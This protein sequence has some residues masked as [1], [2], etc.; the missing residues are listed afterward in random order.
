MQLLQCLDEIVLHA[1]HSLLH[2]CLE[3]NPDESVKCIINDM[4]QPRSVI[5]RGMI[6]FISWSCQFMVSQKIWCH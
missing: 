1:D 6:I 2:S 3:R 4:L 5:P